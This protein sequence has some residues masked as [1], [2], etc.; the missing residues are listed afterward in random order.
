[1]PIVL[2]PKLYEEI[3]KEAD[4]IY[5]KPSAYKSGWIV[6]HYKDAGGRYA[7]DKKPRNLERW[8]KEKWGDIGNK[9]YPVYR[10]FVRVNSKT[11][12]TASEID[13]KQAKEQIKLKQK[14]KGKKNL[15]PFQGMKEYEIQPYTKKKARQLDVLVYPSENPKHK[16]DVYN[17]DG[18]FICSVGARGYSDYPTYIKTHGKAY[19]DNRRRLY[20]IRHTKDSEKIGS[21]GWF[22]DFLLW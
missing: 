18:I 10:P 8:F 3:K 4:Q 16:I 19:A 11:P 14:I 5:S 22:A 13:P 17:D 9:E 20:K 15:P 21:R 7:D 12:L 2:D 1:M 6:K